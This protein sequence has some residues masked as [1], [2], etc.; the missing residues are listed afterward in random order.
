MKKL[1]IIIMV[2]GVIITVVTGFSF[3][4][5]KKVV[6]VGSIEIS[7]NQKHDVEWSPIFGLLTAAVGAGLFF[8]GTR[9]AG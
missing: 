2:L 4:T 1:G 6:D 7:T 5:R 3:F 8:A 9:R